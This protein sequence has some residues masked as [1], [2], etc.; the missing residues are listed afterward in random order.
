M[1]DYNKCSLYYIEEDVEKEKK[2]MESVINYI[3][4]YNYRSRSCKYS[5]YIL[6]IIKMV[7]L[8]IIPVL[9]LA[10]TNGSW[11]VR[12]G[13][14]S[15]FGLLCEALQEAF[16]LKEKWILY[17]NTYNILTSEQRQYAVKKGKYKGSSEDFQKFVENVEEI[18]GDEARKWDKAVK[19]KGTNN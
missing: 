3:E 9:E 14:V 17:R 11:A 6:M 15:F 12:I 8:G 13:M 19:K 2:Y 10:Q 18:I 7:S 5:F 1:K 16:R 4:Y